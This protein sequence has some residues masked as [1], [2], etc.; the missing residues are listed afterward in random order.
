METL[1]RPRGGFE[2]K[3]RF[4]DPA[5]PAPA[6]DQTNQENDAL[7]SNYLALEKRLVAI[8]EKVNPQKFATRKGFVGKIRFAG[9][10]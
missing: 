6:G 10:N 2:S 7:L 4:A 9:G 8:E 1:A 5:P 3:F